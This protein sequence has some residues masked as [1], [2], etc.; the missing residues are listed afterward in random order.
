[1]LGRLGEIGG[2]DVIGR[3]G[4]KAATLARLA[5]AGLPVPDGFVVETGWFER[6]H[7][8]ARTDSVPP[9]LSPELRIAIDVQF[10][11]AAVA[12]RSSAVDE[13]QADASFAG[14]YTTVLDVRGAAAIEEALVRCWSSAYDTRVASYRA[15]QTRDLAQRIGMGVLVQRLVQARLAGVAF[16][17]DPFAGERADTV[18]SAVRGLGDRLVSGEAAADE[19]VVR[20]GVA[21]CRVAPERVLE[22]TT[23]LRIASGWASP[24]RRWRLP[25]SCRRS[26][27]DSGRSSTAALVCPSD[28]HRRMPW[29]MVGSTPR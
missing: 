1:M 4:A 12:V 14:Q 15:L 11:S 29:S 23:A 18:I 19:W 25:G 2:P 24:S 10:G 20:G 8:A 9:D 26:K 22:P 5:Q 3:A 16:T 7:L 27:T 28:Q 6:W 21:T 17:S 13:D